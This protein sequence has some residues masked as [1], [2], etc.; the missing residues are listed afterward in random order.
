[1]ETKIQYHVDK[2]VA[3]LFGRENENDPGQIIYNRLLRLEGDELETW[4]NE[5][6]K[7]YINFIGF[8]CEFQGVEF[9]GIAGPF[10]FETW[11]N[12]HSLREGG[13]LMLYQE[14]Y[15]HSDPNYI[16]ELQ[17]IILKLHDFQ[18][19]NSRNYDRDLH[20]RIHILTDY[21]EMFILSMSTEDLK[22]YIIQQVDPVEFR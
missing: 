7:K 21:M 16:R 20:W 2:F 14:I 5:K 17:D 10:R 6:V 9:E 11:Y 15:D 19:Q 13:D 3:F 12:I 1:M 22:S 8:Y 4:M 18:Q